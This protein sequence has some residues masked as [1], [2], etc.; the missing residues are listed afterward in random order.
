MNKKGK[1]QNL[2]KITLCIEENKIECK[3]SGSDIFFYIINIYTYENKNH[4]HQVF[5]FT[6]NL[7]QQQPAQSGY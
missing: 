7:N 1:Q 2:M 5:L 3:E 4:I 6:W